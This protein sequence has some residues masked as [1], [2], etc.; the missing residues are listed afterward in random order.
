MKFLGSSEKRKQASKQVKKGS[1]W[2]KEASKWKKQ[3]S[4]KGS[5]QVSKKEAS[6]QA[7][8]FLEASYNSQVI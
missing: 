3:A 5:K 4:E 6:K 8:S 2:K 7:R 1:K